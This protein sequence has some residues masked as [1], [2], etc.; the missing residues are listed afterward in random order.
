M[1]NICCILCQRQDSKV[2]ILKTRDTVLKPGFHP[3][4][5]NAHSAMQETG[6]HLIL[7]NTSNV[8]SKTTLAR[9]TERVL[10]LLQAMQEVANGITGIC[11]VQ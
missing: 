6:L 9:E 7:C 4:A 1:C 3:Y 8:R 2:K 10:I 5:C 11:H